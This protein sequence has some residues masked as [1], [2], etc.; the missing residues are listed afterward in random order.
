MGPCPVV[1]IRGMRV[2]SDVHIRKH[3]RVL[4]KMAKPAL[5]GRIM[6]A[7]VRS[8][9]T[10]IP[11]SRTRQRCVSIRVAFTTQRIGVG[12]RIMCGCHRVG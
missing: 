12:V 9:N 10:S 6:P 5:S 8:I 7:R 3:R 1:R 2:E 11:R 4:A